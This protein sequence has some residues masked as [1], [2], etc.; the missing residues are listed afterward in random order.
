MNLKRMHWDRSFRQVWLKDYSP[1]LPYSRHLKGAFCKFCVLFPQKV[2]RGFQGSFIATPFTRYKDFHSYAKEHTK[3]S[4]LM[5]MQLTSLAYVRESRLKLSDVYRKTIEDNR[6]KLYP[7]VST[8]VFCGTHDLSLRGH[9]S[10]CG[11][12][13]D[14][15]QF[16]IESGDEILKSH[17]E[18][19]SHAARYT[20]VR[21][22]NEIVE[23]CGRLLQCDVVH[24]ANNSA[25]FS[26]LADETADTS[27]K[28][29]LSLAVRYMETN[30]A[31]PCIHEEFLGYVHIHQVSAEAI[32]SNSIF[33][34]LLI[35]QA[36]SGC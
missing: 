35:T 29:Q 12:F 13:Q 31:T 33:C 8:I 10:S 3:S 19:A 20:S 16:R 24:A 32:A 6:R 21:T 25:A 7:I 17:I 26:I 9:S 11:N 34:S 36:E 14:L 1:R 30:S 22:Q 15:L 27:G 5:V 2:S 4:W 18:T 23:I 28:E